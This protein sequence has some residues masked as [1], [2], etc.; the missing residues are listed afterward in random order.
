MTGQST[1]EIGHCAWVSVGATSMA[2]RSTEM[3]VRST[4]RIR[5]PSKVRI[6][7]N[8]LIRQSTKGE[9]RRLQPALTFRETAAGVF[10][11]RGGSH[12]FRS[13][14]PQSRV[15]KRQKALRGLTG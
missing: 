7:T 4:G 5:H 12:Q 14:E 2:E 15:E 10:K 1:A 9:E 11:R 8:S 6:G 13:E 3:A